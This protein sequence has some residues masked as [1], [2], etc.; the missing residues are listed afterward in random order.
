MSTL[1]LSDVSGTRRDTPE[2]PPV[3][4]TAGAITKVKQLL[5]GGSAFRLAV[6]GGGCSGFR[7]SMQVENSANLMDK[8]YDI[9]GVRVVIDATSLMYL[10]GARVDFVDTLQGSGFKVE[11]PNV[12]STCG[13]GSSF[14]A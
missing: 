5:R 12:A 14:R 10:R 6:I 2:E 3:H 7:Y 8:V 13:C 1:P 11:N 4:F 9:D